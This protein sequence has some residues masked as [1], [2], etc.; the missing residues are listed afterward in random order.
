MILAGD[1]LQL[2][3]IHQAEAPIGLENVV[4]SMYA[5]YRHANLVPESARRDQLPLE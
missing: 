2:P 3:P 4:G 1:P 5:F